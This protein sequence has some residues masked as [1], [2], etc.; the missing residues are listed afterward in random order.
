[1]GITIGAKSLSPRR[2]RTVAMVGSLPL[3]AV[4]AFQIALGLGA[5]YGDAVLGG[6][7]E[8]VDAV[9]TG[10]YRWAAVGQAGLLLGLAGLLLG[11][12]GMFGVPGLAT[13]GLR[14]AAATIAAFMAL[15]PV[16]N[17]TSPHPLERWIGA[18]TLASAI[19][20]AILAA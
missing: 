1:M 9:L 14:T 12:G 2:L 4:A 7:A 8:T 11:R 16:A 20:I 5:P 17:V 18:G 19:A 13:R 3:I 10:P 6:H 15:H